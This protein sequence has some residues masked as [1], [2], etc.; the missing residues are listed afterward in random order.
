MGS[1]KHGMTIALG[2]GP[3]EHMTH[4]DDEAGGAAG[5][6]SEKEMDAARDL[7][8]AL[9]SGDDETIALALK[10]CWD[11]YEGDEKEEGEE[12]SKEY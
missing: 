2:L 11:L 8:D 7:K 6:V 4:A 12:P 10:H 3:S 9:K 1:P 5:E